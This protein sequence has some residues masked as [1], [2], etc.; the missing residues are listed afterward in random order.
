MLNLKRKAK[1][2]ETYQAQA[3]QARQA[4]DQENSDWPSHQAQLAQSTHGNEDPEIEPYFF[5]LEDAIEANRQILELAGQ[6]NHNLLRPDVLEG[7]LRAQ[8]YWYYE[9]SLIKAAVA[10][11]HGIAQAQAFEDGNKRTAYWALWSWLNDHSLPVMHRNDPEIAYHIIGWGE[12][13]HTMED[14]VALLE[15]RA[16]QGLPEEPP[17]DSNRLYHPSNILDPIHPDLDPRVWEHSD[18]PQ[19]RLRPQHRVWIMQTIHSI[20][21]RHGY[22]S[23]EEWLRLVFTGSLTTYQYSDESDVDISLFVD[24]KIFPEWSRAEMIGIMV[25]EI[26]GT[27]LPGTPFP[28]QCFVVPHDVS[29]QDLYKPGLRSGYSL[30]TDSWIVPP[31]PSRVHDVEKEMNEAYTY[32][33]EVADKMERLLRYEPDKAELFWHQ[34]HRRRKRDQRNERGDYAPSNIAYKMLANR[35]LF[36]VISELTGEYIA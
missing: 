18:G 24:T 33:L 21:E 17:S 1:N 20:F 28:M 13:T 29:P 7:A 3:S 25:G 30:N 31:D 15:Q 32:A 9:Q 23:S 8:N 26:D 14:T 11:A 5:G 16:A 19:P 4:Q 36:P 12:G 6:A 10:M 2:A 35:G 34:I 27:T 22:D